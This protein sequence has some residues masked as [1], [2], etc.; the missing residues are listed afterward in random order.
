MAE[1]TKGVR[2]SHRFKRTK[3]AGAWLTCM[4]NHLNMTELSAEEFRDNL[5]LRYGLKP[6]GLP[7]LCDGCGEPFTVEHAPNYRKGGLVSIWHNN[8]YVKFG[9]M[10]AAALMKAC[11]SDEPKIKHIRPM[12]TDL[13]LPTQATPRLPH[14]RA[15]EIK[16]TSR[17]TD[18]GLKG[19]FVF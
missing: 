10:C 2:L 18:P 3:A 17:S 16:G 11:V 15:K 6:G 12:P 9:D 1:T 4:S 13:P 19:P 14:L 7:K 8:V 5:R